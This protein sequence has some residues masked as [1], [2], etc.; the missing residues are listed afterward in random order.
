MLIMY[1]GIY[2]FKGDAI[3]IILNGVTFHQD[4]GSQ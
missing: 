3:T 1:E 2:N 4:S